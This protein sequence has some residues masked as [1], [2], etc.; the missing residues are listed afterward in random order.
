MSDEP[1]GYQTYI[2][3]LWRPRWQG[4]WQGAAA[5][6][7]QWRASIE[8]PRTGERHVFASLQQLFAYMSELCEWQ[9]PG[10]GDAGRQHL[11]GRRTPDRGAGFGVGPRVSGPGAGERDGRARHTTWFRWI[12]K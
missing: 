9:V 4:E 2:L 3:R 1:N 8:S 11:R 7:G 12:P 10:D 5:L 6:G